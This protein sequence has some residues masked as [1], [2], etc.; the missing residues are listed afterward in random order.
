M[1][2]SSVGTDVAASALVSSVTRCC[3]S[4]RPRAAPSTARC[5]F[6]VR[7]W[8]AS[9]PARSSAFNVPRPAAS[10]TNACG[11]PSGVSTLPTRRAIVTV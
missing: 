10:H 9:T 2:R 7:R 1:R 6:A 3:I 4:P 11:S 8:N 5:S